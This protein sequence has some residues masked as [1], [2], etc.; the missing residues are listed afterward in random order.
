MSVRHF[1]LPI[2]LLIVMLAPVPGVTGEFRLPRLWRS[3]V[4]GLV[5]ACFGAIGLAFA[6]F[7]PFVNSLAFGRPERCGECRSTC[8]HGPWRSSATQNSSR[9]R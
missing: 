3:I 8:G 2:A 7:V 4:V 9:R 5:I 1:M 6:Y